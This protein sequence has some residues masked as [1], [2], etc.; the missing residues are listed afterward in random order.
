[1]MRDKSEDAWSSESV[2]VT[3]G[4][5]DAPRP[6]RPHDSRLCVALGAGGGRG[7]DPTVCSALL[8]WARQGQQ[9]VDDRGLQGICPRRAQPWEKGAY[10][11]GADPVSTRKGAGRSSRGN[12][13]G[14]GLEA[15][16]SCVGGETSGRQYWRRRQP[17][18]AKDW[19]HNLAPGNGEPAR[20]LEQGS[21]H[22]S[23]LS[24]HS[25]LVSLPGRR[26]MVVV[27]DR[28]S[29]LYQK[30]YWASYNIPYVP[31]PWYPRP[32]AQLS[33][34]GRGASQVIL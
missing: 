15:A 20:V 17:L 13:Q 9:P 19:G 23:P 30:T 27:A 29:E 5:P 24:H 2:R 31:P 32:F 1:M 34:L 7:S 33:V 14:R 18:I 22:R 11:P 4:R 12:C 10:H 3:I 8:P 6:P 25:C 16:E 21:T 28:T 26:G